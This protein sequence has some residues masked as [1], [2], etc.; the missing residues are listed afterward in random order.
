MSRA[1]LWKK[2]NNNEIQCQACN[3]FCTVIPEERGKCG[4]RLNNNGEMETLVKDKIAA[5]NLDPIE[6]KP[7]FHFMPGTQTLSLGTM[8]C[9]LACTFCQNY[10]L[11]QP[12]KE[13]Q[14]PIGDPISPNQILAAA[15]EYSASSISYTYSEP[16]I[17]IELLLE[18]ADLA[19]KS[20]L[21]NIIVSNGFQSPQ[22]M[23]AMDG[24]IDAANIDLKAFSED[25]YSKY[26]GARLKPV[27]QNLVRIRKMGW[28]LEVT[29]L[30]IPGLNDSPEE[31]EQMAGF[32]CNELGEDTPWHISRFHPTFKMTDRPATP[33][34]TLERACSAGLGAGL[35]F[36]YTGNIPG[37][38]AESTFCPSCKKMIIKRT[39][40]KVREVHMKD[41]ACSFCQEEIPGRWEN[42]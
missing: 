3:H 21:K 22:C 14:E 31:L 16:T 10:S 4:V 27:L 8:G 42:S 25:F 17:F 39:G 18:T 40:F 11:S 34:E 7:L 29:T 5:L 28:W 24:Y 26:C 37:H 32:I 9:N 36:V 35:K 15:V 1:I 38:M 2:L 23:N 41:G 20:G 6:K 12:P 13:Q 30:L 19:Q 33:V